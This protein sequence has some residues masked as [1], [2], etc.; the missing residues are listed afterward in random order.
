M[1][2]QEFSV[3]KLAERIQSEADAYMLLEE[4][5][6]GGAPDTCPHCGG[7][8]RCYFL[9]PKNGVGRATRTGSA[10]SAA[11]GSAVTAA[12]SSPC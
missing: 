2:K 9:E 3:P 8:D 6:W 11:S 5:R 12:S 1:S 7:M 10:L 4:L